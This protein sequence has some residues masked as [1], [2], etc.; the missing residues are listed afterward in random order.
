MDAGG[1]VTLP[2]LPPDADL[3]ARWTMD[4]TF[5][6]PSTP[7]DAVYHAML[8]Q[9]QYKLDLTY[10]ERAHAELGDLDLADR[11][12]LHAPGL[13]TPYCVEMNFDQDS[14]QDP[15]RYTAPGC[16]FTPGTSLSAGIGAGG[17]TWPPTAQIGQWGLGDL[18]TQCVQ[19]SFKTKTPSTTGYLNSYRGTIIGKLLRASGFGTSGWSLYIL[20]YDMT[21]NWFG[22]YNA[23]ASGSLAIPPQPIAPGTWY[24]VTL[25]WD[26]AVYTWWMN[27]LI[28]GSHASTAPLQS[29]SGIFT[30]F[31]T[32]ANGVMGFGLGDMDMF[33]YGFVDQIS[34]WSSPANVDRGIEISF[35]EETHQDP[36]WTRVDDPVGV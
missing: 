11:P 32:V 23:D 30:S 20:Y 7:G 18:E 34:I 19:I 8:D 4:D 22:T 33:F 10:L 12:T 31:L 3:L 1:N 21:L 27:G 25:S 15:G 26:G 35:T 17:V 13:V 24:T 16:Y 9:G 6:F 14:M 5:A 28:V 29:V 2:L 36:D